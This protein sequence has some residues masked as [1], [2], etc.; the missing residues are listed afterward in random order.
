MD[1]FVNLSKFDLLL[2]S[3]SD[4]NLHQMNK[5]TL[6]IILEKYNFI[7]NKSFLKND[8]ITIIKQI[9]EKL[10]EESI[11]SHP[12]NEEEA[13]LYTNSLKN[14]YKNTFS[15]LSSLVEKKE[16]KKGK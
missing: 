12:L 2:L 15:E 13:I 14:G 11:N 6:L 4:S 1:T 5:D 9:K 8:L 16:Q 3:L 7:P 10:T